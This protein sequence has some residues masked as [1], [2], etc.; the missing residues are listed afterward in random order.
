MPI[1]VP[2]LVI[3]VL[4]F[5]FF[6][7]NC[8]RPQKQDNCPNRCTSPKHGQCSIEL[9]QCLCN[10]RYFGIDCS[11]FAP[12]ISAKTSQTLS[13]PPESEHIIY[14]YID[15]TT[16]NVF[17]SHLKKGFIKD[18]NFEFEASHNLANYFYFLGEKN[19]LPDQMEL[20]TSHSASSGF[21]ISSETLEPFEGGLLRIK[22]QNFDKELSLNLTI[23]SNSGKQF[24]VTVLMRKRS[25]RSHGFFRKICSTYILGTF[26]NNFYD[27]LGC[28][29]T[30]M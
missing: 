4:L 29:R 11:Q 30:N 3:V 19:V 15:C 24:F 7:V 26:G 20:I 2:K 8:Q 17:Q 25:W 10:P 23:K 9:Q 14:F 21:K 6:H 27:D 28:C 1:P 12:L 13:I 5:I 16:F 22:I 18:V